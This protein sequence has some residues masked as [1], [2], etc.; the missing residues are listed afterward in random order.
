M[1]YHKHF[2][3][4]RLKSNKLQRETDSSPLIPHQRAN[5]FTAALVPSW[6]G[7]KEM[8]RENQVVQ[9]LPFGAGKVNSTKNKK[10]ELEALNTF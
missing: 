4:S 6:S 9:Q 1:S 3:V 5:L 10:S 7:C 8:G 2:I